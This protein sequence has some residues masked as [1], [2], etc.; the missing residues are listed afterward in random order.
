MFCFIFPGAAL[1]SDLL[2]DPLD[3]SCKQP[4]KINR[5]Q[6]SIW[7]VKSSLVSLTSINV[8]DLHL[9]IRDSL[10]AG[11]FGRHIAGEGGGTG[12]F[13]AAVGC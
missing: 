10:Q 5:L 13:V 1:W 3:D 9:C 2:E 12:Q 11:L 6:K 4:S 7:L 8:P